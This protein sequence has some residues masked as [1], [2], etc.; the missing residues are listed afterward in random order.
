MRVLRFLAAL[1]LVAHIAACAHSPAPAPP[2]SRVASSAAGA[3]AARTVILISIDGF[4]ADYIGR[5]HTPT[6]AR[7]AAEGATTPGM[8]PSFPS[9]TFPNHYTLVTGRRPD[10]HGVVDNVFE[11]QAMTPPRFDK[12]DK[13]TA[14]EP[15]WWEGAAPLWV[16]AERQ[17]VRTATMFWPGSEAA[18][19]GVRPSYWAAFDKATTS[20]QRT[21]RLLEWLDRPAAERP[22]FLTLYFNIVDGAGHEFGPDSPEVNQA[23]ATVDTAIGRLIDGLKARGL[24]D[25]TDLVVVADHGMAATSAQRRILLD[26][27]VPLADVRTIVTGPVTGL[28]PLPGREAEVERRLLA[29]HDHIQCWRKAQLPARFAYG[30]N[31]RAPP[32]VCLAETGWKVATRQQAARYDAD[33]SHQPGK[34]GGDHG[35]DPADPT[36]AALFIARGPDSRPGAVLPP[37]DNV[38]V[39]PL[40]ARLLGVKPE[41]GDGRLEDVAPALLK[42]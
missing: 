1:G 23:A 25:A 39:Y 37:F 11:D 33:P 27:L 40:L 38:D 36:M 7:L 14:N 42:P 9:V 30:H 28:A 34:V 21:D 13:A 32:I 6:L 12:N 18:I 8:R 31:P 2:A 22:R 24:Y 35:Y 20:N 3:A 26:D 10:G 41:P 19:F 4:R 15:R 16:S 17:G 5:G 29:P